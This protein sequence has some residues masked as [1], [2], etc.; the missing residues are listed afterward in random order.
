MR[1]AA[2]K[3]S[4]GL[5]DVQ[6]LLKD[7]RPETRI[8]VARNVAS[9]FDD[10]SLSESEKAIAIDILRA[11]ARDAETRVR[12]AIS[13]TLKS[14][15]AVPRD[16]ALTLAKDEVAIVAN[17]VLRASPV[18]SDD[19]LL[20]VLAEGRGDKQIAIAAR[21]M[22]SQT[23]SAAVV[24]TGN[25]AAV[26]T[27]VTNEGA[28]IGEDA[29]ADALDRYAEFD[30]IKSGLV[31]RAELPITI[32]ER[33]V[34]MVSDKL[35]VELVRKH[36]VSPEIAADVLLAAREQATVRILPGASN[37]LPALVRQL[38][39]R[40]RL[41]PS[42]ILRALCTGDIR[43]FEEAVGQLANVSTA[44]AAL[45]IHDAGHL[46]LKAVYKRAGLPDV[47]FPAFRVAVDVVERT[48]LDPGPDGRERYERRVIERILTQ[49]HAMEVSD[50][51]YLL[52]KLNAAA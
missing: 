32:A 5:D 38:K 26:T 1:Y 25:A 15:E 47:F 11:M 10:S 4:L 22:V 24:A 52:G 49:Y 16:I 51:D 41:T 42:L 6:A 46:G 33:L 44:K 40:G 35:K 12:A 29:M 34:A 14:N 36:P 18:L 37:D 43:F 28:N 39:N 3:I 27:L 48:E 19:D 9:G 21:P 31:G 2:P 8:T 50:L 7:P 20:A 13:D 45:L 30:T 17:P 23:V